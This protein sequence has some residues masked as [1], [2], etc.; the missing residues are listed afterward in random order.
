MT[1]GTE[2]KLFDRVSMTWLEPAEWERRRALNEE[3]LFLERPRQGELAAP[4]VLRDG[5]DPVQSQVDGRHYD[6]KSALRRSYRHA[7]V[8]EVGD[9]PTYTQAERLQPGPRVTPTYAERQRD[10]KAAL[11]RARS[12]V[13]LTSYRSEE[14]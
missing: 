8:T 5:M 13:N 11:E 7:G 14:V 1:H 3:R 4:M 10:I 12:R 6:S 9:E 2:G